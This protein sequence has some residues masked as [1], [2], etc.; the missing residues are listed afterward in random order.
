M[1]QIIEAL[2][3]LPPLRGPIETDQRWCI[4]LQRPCATLLPDSI[5]MT[6]LEDGTIGAVL[7][8]PTMV[9]QQKDHPNPA[10]Q[11]LFDGSSHPGW[12]SDRLGEGYSIF[13]RLPAGN[14]PQ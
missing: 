10:L 2:R 11:F 4:Y 8:S 3:R 1:L 13:Y 9:N 14:A 7:V 12:R 5:Q 6:S